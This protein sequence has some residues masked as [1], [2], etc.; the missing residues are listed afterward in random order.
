L[1]IENALFLFYIIH[2]CGL[3]PQYEFPIAN[4]LNMVNM[5]GVVRAIPIKNVP[6]IRI[7]FKLGNVI[8]IHQTSLGVNQNQSTIRKIKI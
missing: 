6:C 1:A 2:R 8:T 4:K 3:I 7:D 5:K